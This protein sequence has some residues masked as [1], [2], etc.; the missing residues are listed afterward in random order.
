VVLF[1]S[2]GTLTRGEVLPKPKRGLQDVGDDN[3][4]NIGKAT[5]F[6]LV[7]FAVFILVLCSSF[8]FILVYFA[9]FIFFVSL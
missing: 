4:I 6:I 3:M 8:V 7:L 2:Y 9:A 5:V 1:W